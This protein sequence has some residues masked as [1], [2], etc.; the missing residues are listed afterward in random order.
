MRLRSRQRDTRPAGV[1]DELIR[2]MQARQQSAA[3]TKQ[4]AG[5][6]R[7]NEDVI[8]PG[9]ETAGESTGSARRQKKKRGSGSHARKIEEAPP[10]HLHLMYGEENQGVS[11][12]GREDGDG[13]A[14]GA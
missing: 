8:A 6:R 11:H 12:Q 14:S 13:D 5:S 10:S 2:Q 1:V 3:P 4:Q 9:T 7:A